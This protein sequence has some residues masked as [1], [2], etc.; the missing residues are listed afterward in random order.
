MMAIPLLYFVFSF[1]KYEG[2]YSKKIKIFRREA[3]FNFAI[4]FQTVF[5]EAYFYVWLIQTVFCGSNFCDLGPKS[6]K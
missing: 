4:G 5:S 1:L 2:S 6:E 3:E